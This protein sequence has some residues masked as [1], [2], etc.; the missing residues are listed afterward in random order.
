MAGPLTRPE[1]AVLDACRNQGPR[2]QRGLATQTGL[3]LGYVNRTT[4]RLKA[5]GLLSADSR[6]T[7]AGLQALEPYKVTN[8]II[9]AAGT[10]NRFAPVTFE[11][12]KGLLVVKGEVL[13]ERQI[14]QLRE[15]GIEDIA[16]V[17][18]Y[19]QEQFFYLEDAFG[20]RIV[21]NPDYAERHTNSSIKAAE[22]LLDNTYICS[23]DN[24]F[25]QNVFSSHVYSGYAAAVWH[26]G[27]T[28]EWGLAATPTGR[29]TEAR[30]GAGDSWVMM[31]H[32]YWDRDFSLRFRVILNS[33]Y[34]RQETAP[35]RW[36]AVY[37]DHTAELPLQIRTYEPGVIYEFDTLDDLRRFD[38]SFLSNVDSTILDNICTTLRCEAAELSD[39][40][41]VVGGLTNL[42]VRF[43]HAGQDYVYRHPGVAT[44][45][46]I[47]RAVEAQAEAV[48]SALGVDDT[49]IHMDPA[50]GWKLSYFMGDTTP[51]DYHNRDHVTR[52]LSA[53]RRLH[54][55]GRTV[56]N[57]LD[58]YA[59][60]AALKQRL[61]GGGG[62]DKSA[63]LGFPE[64]ARLDEQASRINDF[65]RAEA[66]PGVLCHN[67][68]YA[69]NI[70]IAGDKLAVIDWEYAG[71]GDAAG[72]LGTF[73][74]C[75]DYTWEEA[76]EVFTT[77]YGRLPTAQELRH[78]TAYVALAAYYWWVWALYKDACGDALG[79]WPYVWYRFA[80]DYGLRALAMFQT[81]DVTEITVRTPLPMP[82]RRTSVDSPAA[83]P[84]SL[85]L[86]SSTPDLPRLMA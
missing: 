47:D 31:G 18:G 12:P 84:R 21:I 64:F 59:Q 56:G 62:I 3:S 2:S 72:D 50:V 61:S 26:D 43:R 60:A 35:K 11:R 34:D 44:N 63:R 77:Y 15:A 1:F 37:A 6:I 81:G 85:R 5:S 65:C 13:I 36:E 38:P 52:A 19:R 23:S 27:P 24:Y 41:L 71:M 66:V 42:S 75:S 49:F 45:G 4:Q 53:M 46:V 83:K 80:K 67:D 32:S 79:N 58:L 78:C 20:V 73:I 10:S 82:R 69:S 25:T 54:T 48:A 22:S 51:F 30:R 68:F 9:L 8:A 74:C 17:V 39:F 86:T 14:R 70:L 55:S 28:R 57:T 16:V 7:D 40:A 33:E 29:I 76:Q